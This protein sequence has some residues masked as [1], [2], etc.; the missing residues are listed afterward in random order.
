MKKHHY[1]ES[2]ILVTAQLVHKELI[3]RE[4]AIDSLEILYKY[5]ATQ[6]PKPLFIN[7]CHN[8]SFVHDKETFESIE[9]ALDAAIENIKEF[10]DE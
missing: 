10:D 2:A 1:M 4:T 6:K 5:G 9:D 7:I 3:T 8:G